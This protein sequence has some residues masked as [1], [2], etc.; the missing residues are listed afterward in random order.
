[1]EERN[2]L[3]CERTSS[4]D[5]D[6]VG[7]PIERWR[8]FAIIVWWAGGGIIFG[9]NIHGLSHNP[10]RQLAQVPARILGFSFI[11]S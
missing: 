10:Q 2:E 9:A 1:M 3:M 7:E 4:L 11:R 8:E 6:V 5:K